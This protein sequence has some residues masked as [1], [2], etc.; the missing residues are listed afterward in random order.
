M[1]PMIKKYIKEDYEAVKIEI[2]E[3]FKPIFL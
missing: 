2:D 1:L 3:N